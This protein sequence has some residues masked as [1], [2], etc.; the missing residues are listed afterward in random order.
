MVDAW[1]EAQEVSCDRN[2]GDSAS[3][4]RVSLLQ[5]LSKREREVLS[6]VAEGSGN[7]EIGS[8][9]GISAETVKTHLKGLSSKLQARDRAH[10]TA[11]GIRLGLI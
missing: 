3:V 11:V 6:L 4:P 5:S 8:Q 9:L 1:Y 10:A 2:L 7:G